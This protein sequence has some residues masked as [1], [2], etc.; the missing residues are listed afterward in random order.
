[1]VAEQI[2]DGQFM[3]GGGQIGKNLASHGMMLHCGSGTK[4]NNLEVNSHGKDGVDF[5][6]D[7]QD[8]AHYIAS[9]FRDPA[10][11]ALG[12]PHGSGAGQP[13]KDQFNTICGSGVG[14]ID[15]VAGTSVYFKFTD[16][17]EPGKQDTAQILIPGP[18]STVM[19]MQS[20]SVENGTCSLVATGTAW[21]LNVSGTIRG[22]HQAH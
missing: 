1:V 18:G 7:D 13:N 8:S 14:S 22:N 15:G 4:P 21:K 5:H 10:V 17:G 3:T 6:M 9:C 12:S 2:E 20:G 19:I 11:T 16:A